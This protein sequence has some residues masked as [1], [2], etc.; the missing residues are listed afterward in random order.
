VEILARGVLSL[1][2]AKPINY[3][4]PQL[5]WR[6]ARNVHE[7]HAFTALGLALSD[8]HPF[9]ADAETICK[10]LVGNWRS[11]HL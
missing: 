3:E 2:S 7:S 1:F 11:E 10:S 5:C 8:G 6:C 9:K 4:F